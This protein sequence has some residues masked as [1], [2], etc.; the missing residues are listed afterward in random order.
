M[1]S[2][3]EITPRPL[4]INKLPTKTASKEINAAQGLLDLRVD[5]ETEIQGI[6]MGVLSDG[7]P[8]LT[9]RGLARLCGVMN[10]HVGTIG[11]EWNENPQKPRISIVRDLLAKRGITVDAPYLEVKDGGR[12]IHAYPD[13]VCLAVLE[14]Y[15]FEAG[16]NCKTE[17][18]DNFRLLAGKALQDF[19]YTQVGYDPQNSVPDV[20]R[21]FHDRVGLTYNSVPAGY[22][23]VFK[24]ISDMIVT[25]I[26]AGAQ[27][28]SSF[29]P[30]I[31]VGQAWS[32]YWTEMGRS[33]AYGERRKYEHNYPG[34][35]PQAAVNP[36]EPWCY[37]EEA[38]G[39]F[40]RW[41][42]EQY[43]GEGKFANYLSTKVKKQ[44]LPISFAQLAIAAYS[45]S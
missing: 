34:Y 4:K 29:I 44:E 7:T 33:G 12:V 28:D 43:I 39:E 27:I 1:S 35:F 45:D 3:K 11:A 6:G 30:D 37:P 40:R 38:L 17:A 32:R 5:K 23:G 15:A 31:S 26:Q 2:P 10:A 22:F 41:F 13:A 21:Q 19:I 16:S 20:W 42:R 14:Y 36:Q 9:Q 25:L 8:F 18:R 24:E